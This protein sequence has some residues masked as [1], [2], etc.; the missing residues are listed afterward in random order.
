VYLLTLV[1]PQMYDGTETAPI[2]YN[3]L[4]TDVRAALENLST[5]GLVAVTRTAGLNSGYSWTVSFITECGDLPMMTTTAGR[6]QGVAATVTVTEATR[7]TAATVVYKGKD[8]GVKSFTATGLT[9]DNRYAYKVAPSNKR[10]SSLV[11]KPILLFLCV[12]FCV[13][14]LFCDSVTLCFSQ[15][16]DDSSPTNSTIACISSYCTHYCLPPQLALAFPA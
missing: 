4:D 5:I 10:K 15:A 14:T 12:V 16:H 11:L 9:E 13:V 3:A 7:G 8:P 1:L 2:A 6:L